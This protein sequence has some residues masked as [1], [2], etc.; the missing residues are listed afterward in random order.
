[1]P[2]IYYSK[3]LFTF[4]ANFEVVLNIEKLGDVELFQVR[5]VLKILELSPRTE[6]HYS[7]K[8]GK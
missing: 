5:W 4:I 1:M 7:N 8:L 2:L 3:N 6:H